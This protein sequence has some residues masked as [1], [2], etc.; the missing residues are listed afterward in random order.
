M[1]WPV[2]KWPKHDHFRGAERHCPCIL[3]TLLSLGTEFHCWGFPNELVMFTKIGQVIWGL[4][5]E[6]P[7][8]YFNSHFSVL[9]YIWPSLL[10]QW[11]STGQFIYAVHCYYSFIYLACTFCTNFRRNSPWLLLHI[12]LTTISD[13]MKSCIICAVI[14]LWYHQALTIKVV[15]AIRNDETDMLKG[16]LLF[17]WGKKYMKYEA[18]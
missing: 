15:L 14:Y 16:N 12:F 6:L 11:E 17:L 10:N 2:W 1:S 4:P 9:T 5:D 18:V 3:S 13:F 7:P 8:L